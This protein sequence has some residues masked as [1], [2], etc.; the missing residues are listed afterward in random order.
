MEARLLEMHRKMEDSAQERKDAQNEAKQAYKQQV[1][2]EKRLEGLLGEHRQ[3]QKS[4]EREIKRADEKRNEAEVQLYKLQ[5]TMQALEKR[6]AI[7]D[8]EIVRLSQIQKLVS[9]SVSRLPAACVADLNEQE[10]KEAKEDALHQA[11]ISLQSADKSRDQLLT[12][13]EDLENRQK[14]AYLKL[15][16]RVAD[17][18]GSHMSKSVSEHMAAIDKKAQADKTKNANQLESERLL[19]AAKQ[20][21]SQTLEDLFR[22]YNV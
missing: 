19:K 12:K 14:R 9:E 18:V 1:D 2:A 11:L 3:A 22:K 20:A 5:L 10:V 16:E 7:Q 13:I 17:E 6:I 4:W 15:Y 21:E 8:E